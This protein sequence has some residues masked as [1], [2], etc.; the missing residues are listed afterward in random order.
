[1]LKTNRSLLAFILLSIITLG[2]Y[3]LFFWH[4]YAKEMNVAC[5]GDGKH[6][7]GI[8]FRIIVGA[9]TFGIYEFVW[10]YSAGDRIA[11]Y[12]AKRNL[13]CKTSGGSV[14]LWFIFGSML[15]GIGP[16]VAMY[17]LFNGMNTVCS[18]YNGRGRSAGANVT[19]NVNVPNA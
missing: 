5:G 19:V 8:I 2:I 6:T 16:F 1:M 12:C 9:I 11:Y 17:K 18:D 3:P 10:L 14:L 4:K 7:R 15:F 13:P